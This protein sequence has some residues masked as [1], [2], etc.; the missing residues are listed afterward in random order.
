MVGS[1]S[2]LD[3]STTVLAFTSDRLNELIFK[4][5]VPIVLDLDSPSYNAWRTCFV[6]LFRSYC[7]IDNV[8][9]SIDIRDMKGDEEWLAIDACIVKWLFLTISRGLFDMVNCRDPSADV[10]WTRFCDLFLDN[11]LQRR[12]FLQGKFFTMQQNDLMMD[13]YCTKLNVLSA[14]LRGVGMVVDD[15]VLLTNLLRG[16]HPILVQSAANLSLTMPSSAKVVTYLRMEEK[17]LRHA[18][19]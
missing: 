7:L 6:L 19:R 10:I 18:D 13:E 2:S 5:H 15:S 11:Q 12:V 8:D 17:C 4:D 3:S 14:E 16:L 9:G 1:S